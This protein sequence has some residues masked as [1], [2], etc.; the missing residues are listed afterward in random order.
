MR[1][2]LTNCHPQ[3]DGP[4]VP[5]DRPRPTGA[6]IA[7]K[8]RERAQDARLAWEDYE[9]RNRAVEANMARLRELRLA[10]DAG[11]EPTAKITKAR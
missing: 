7:E 6:E 5:S 4:S 8:R 3:P 1:R 9:A 2:S 10:R 11:G